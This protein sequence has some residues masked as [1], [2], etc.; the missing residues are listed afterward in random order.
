MHAEALS[1]T[2]AEVDVLLVNMPFGILVT[3]SLGLGLLQASLETLGGVRSRQRYF[4]L[5]FCKKLGFDDYQAIA[6]RWGSGHEEL[7]DW[8]FS[9]VA[10]PDA[11][12]AP[13]EY[14]EHIARNPPKELE[15]FLPGVIPAVLRAA[16]AARE[17]AP[18]FIDEC[19]REIEAMKP[20]VV[21]FTSMF[22]QRVASIA[23]AR[24]IKEWRPETIIVMGGADCEEARGRA[25]AKNFRCIDAVCSGP[26]DVVFPEIVRRALAGQS[27][28][29]IPGVY[30]GRTLMGTATPNA[31]APAKLDDVPYPHFDDY[32]TDL[33]A[34]GLELPV[35]YLS[36][37]T[38]RGCWWGER[39]HCTFCSI[40]GASMGYAS[41]SAPRVVDEI[42]F[43]AAK[44]PGVQMVMTDSILNVKHLRTAIP[45][46]KAH[47]L[48]LDM[49]YEVRA[50]LDPEQ[51]QLLTECG[52]RT[53]QPG[54]ETFSSEV[55]TLM[56][57]NTSYLMNVRL[58]KLGRMHGVSVFY[59]ILVG[60]PDE[61]AEAYFKM[62]RLLPK[63][64]HLEPPKRMRIIEIGRHS[65][66]FEEADALGVTN[67]EPSPAYRHIYPVPPAALRDL[68]TYF[69]YSYKNPQ[70]LDA[71][72]GPVAV[73]L[74]KWW[75][76]QERSTLQVAYEAERSMVFEGRPAFGER[77]TILRG[78]EHRLHRA[79][80]DIRKL[81]AL[82]KEFAGQG[83]DA[84][85]DEALASLEERGF[86]VRDEHRLMSLAIPI[87]DDVG[88]RV[89]KKSYPSDYQSRALG[90][91]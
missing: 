5:D 43:F 81:D 38:S 47:G 57:K 17:L 15:R 87:R 42:R 76:L 89:K 7:G 86:L 60:F 70:D 45:E 11:E 83:T 12:L 21:A 73:E 55:L 80:E 44:Y 19:M 1:E 54:I 39:N 58:L 13:D 26:G 28:G 2:T 72:V 29:N 27:L 56:R 50:T 90:L 66:L 37:E 71:Y 6:N 91:C 30:T 23:L 88:A 41:K 69:T 79:C 4:A 32:F 3:P 63:I 36:L 64:T 84:E 53:L 74:Q 18:A 34:S 40:N 52:V 67:L 16:L 8:V 46:L 35:L 10:F 9:G 49:M 22:Q 14:L 59:N 62:S 20:R 77:I 61:P 31:E 48:D 78:L 82:K 68:A 65:P 51:F 25:I 85:I 33:R 75:R 24:R